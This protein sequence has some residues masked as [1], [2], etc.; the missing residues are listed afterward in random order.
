LERTHRVLVEFI[1]HFVTQ[2]QTDWDEWVKYAVF[3]YNTTPHSATGFTPFELMLGRIAN[4]PGYLQKPPEQ[5]TYN[6]DSYVQELK[7]RLQHSYAV[8]RERLEAAKKRSKEYY[9]KQIHVPR[10]RVGDLLLLQY[11]SPRKNR[12]RKLGPSWIGPYTIKEIKGVNVTLQFRK[13]KH[14]TVH[15]NRLKPFLCNLQMWITAWVA[16]FLIVGGG[17]LDFRLEPIPESPGL[18]KPGYPPVN[19]EF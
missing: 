16:C 14:R 3:A 9:D 11:E 7:R 8:A 5:I 15:A 18:E 1:R 10:F 19:G 2:D 13:G 4:L 12:S 17:S 6:L